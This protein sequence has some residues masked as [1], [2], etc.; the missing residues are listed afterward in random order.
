MK[1][2]WDKT[3]DSFGRKVYRTK[4]FEIR[5]ANKEQ[6]KKVIK[7]LNS[8]ASYIYIPKEIEVVMLKKAER[9]CKKKW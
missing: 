7:L 3:R 1:L 5:N 2:L 4:R 8:N 6:L 9:R